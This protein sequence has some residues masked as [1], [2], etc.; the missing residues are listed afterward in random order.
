MNKSNV[1]TSFS[2]IMPILNE[3]KRIIPAIATLGLTTKYPFELLVIYDNDQ[4]I[5]IPV[6]NELK[7]KFDFIKLKKNEGLKVIGAI[8]TGFIHAE[9]DIVGIWLPYHV[10]PYGLI[11]KMYEKNQR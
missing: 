9:S 8:K 7:L 3:G 11:N 2:L 1:T 6:I 4:D 5:T 10:D